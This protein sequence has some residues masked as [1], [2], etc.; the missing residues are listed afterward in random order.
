[1]L[2]TIAC[3]FTAALLSFAAPFAAAPAQAEAFNITEADPV[4]VITVPDDWEGKKVGRGIQIK[5]PDD[6]IYMWVELIPPNEI[7]A[8]QKEHNSYFDGQGVKI[9]SAG[10]TVQVEFNG[11]PWVISELKA[12]AKGEDSVIRYVAIN[13]KVASGKLILLTYWASLEGDKKYN[14][15]TTKMLENLGFK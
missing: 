9:E 10:E 1:M 11:R 14:D 13:P 12:K 7:D 5:T 3:A 8:V 6:E 15:A 2:R 4:A